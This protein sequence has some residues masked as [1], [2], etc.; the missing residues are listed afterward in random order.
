VRNPDYV[1]NEHA[2][3]IRPSFYTVVIEGES[4]REIKI[5]YI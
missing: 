1:V 4:E 5:Q 2:I 3:N